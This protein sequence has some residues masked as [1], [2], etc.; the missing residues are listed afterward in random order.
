MEYTGTFYRT[1][2]AD[3]KPWPPPDLLAAILA[4]DDGGQFAINRKSVISPSAYLGG[5]STGNKNAF[6][7]NRQFSSVDLA[8]QSSTPYARFS[9]VSRRDVHEVLSTK[10]KTRLKIRR[11]SEYRNSST[12]VSVSVRFIQLITYNHGNRLSS[13]SKTKR[14]KKNGLV[15]P[16]PAGGLNSEVLTVRHGKKK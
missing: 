6:C 14:E 11:F 9:T 16:T 5:Y 2:P 7:R 12:P 3:R 13:R 15:L 10:N 1:H 4:R 8:E